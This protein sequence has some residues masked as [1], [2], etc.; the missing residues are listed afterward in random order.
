MKITHIVLAICLGLSGEMA[1]AGAK[2]RSIN[3]QLLLS[4]TVCP[5]GTV[6]EEYTAGSAGPTAVQDATMPKLSINLKNSDLRTTLHLLGEEM[7][8]GRLHLDNAVSGNIDLREFDIP[9]DKLF[10]KVLQ[11]KNL[12][13]MKIKHNYYVF[14]SSMGRSVAAS[15]AALKGL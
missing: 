11:M 4:E 5:V 3:G 14:P 12:D 7:F 13:V 6:V 15:M 8:P 1:L 9:A 10:Y 2:C